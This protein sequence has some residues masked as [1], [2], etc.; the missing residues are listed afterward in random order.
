VTCG[1]PQ[2]RHSGQTGR[3]ARRISG[4]RQAGTKLTIQT[5]TEFTDGSGR[6]NYLSTDTFVPLR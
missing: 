2:A 5:W 6:S 3:R 4:T 1:R